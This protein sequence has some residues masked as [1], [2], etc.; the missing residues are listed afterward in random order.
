[1]LPPPGWQK[2]DRETQ[3]EEQSYMDT[4]HWADD[5]PK[6]YHRP[7]RFTFIPQARGKGKKKQ[8][9]NKNTQ[10]QKTNHTHTRLLTD[11]VFALT[12]KLPFTDCHT[13][14][15]SFLMFLSSHCS[16]LPEVKFLTSC[17]L[18]RASRKAS[19]GK[20]HAHNSLLR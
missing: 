3:V 2:Q 17:A 20:H 13:F 1:M 5:H 8:K 12:N 9:T 14:N 4:D 15:N 18:T 11:K 16:L 7:P 6:Q 10:T 19:M